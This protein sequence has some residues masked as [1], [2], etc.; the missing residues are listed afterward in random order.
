MIDAATRFF[1]LRRSN[2]RSV[3]GDA[4]DYV[5]SSRNTYDAVL[6][7][8]WGSAAECRRL[9]LTTG[10]LA[11]TLRRLAPHGVF[12]A[13]VPATDHWTAASVDLLKKAG[14]PEA[15]FLYPPLGPTAVVVGGRK[16]R[17]WASITRHC[18][19]SGY[20]ADVVTA[21]RFVQRP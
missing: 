15:A 17:P 14:F 2:P 7:D 16:F 10:Y 11:G 1:R 12:A 6:D 9:P 19:H 3:H 21:V 5:R 20:A 13:N 8:L 4:V 18:I